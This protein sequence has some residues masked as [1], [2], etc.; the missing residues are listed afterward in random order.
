M[1]IHASLLLFI[2]IIIVSFTNILQAKAE[3]NKTVTT[4][5]D[6]NITPLNSSKDSPVPV[7]VPVPVPSFCS[8][9]IHNPNGSWSPIR[10]ITI[11][12]S[13][14]RIGLGPGI[15]FRRGFLFSGIDLAEQL[16]ASCVVPGS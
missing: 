3:D 12:T 11:A 8:A 5:K 4:Q 14:G 1:K 16:E 7:P 10:P 9:F 15:S 6:V 13:M 2:A